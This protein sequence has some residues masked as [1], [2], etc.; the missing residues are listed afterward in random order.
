ML[1][2]SS[3]YAI[4]FRKVQSLVFQSRENKVDCFEPHGRW[5]EYLA[6]GGVCEDAVLNTI[7][8]EVSIKVGL[9]FIDELEVILD[10]NSYE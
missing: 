5:S 6:F 3:G 2:S 8:S 9:G 10:N 4:D 7:M 1:H